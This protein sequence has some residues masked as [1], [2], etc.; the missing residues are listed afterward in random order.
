MCMTESRLQVS[1][2]LLLEE[3]RL[4][5]HNFPGTV[6]GSPTTPQYYHIKHQKMICRGIQRRTRASSVA[7]EARFKTLNQVSPE[8][9]PSTARKPTARTRPIESTSSVSSQERID[10]I[11]SKVT[12]FPFSYDDLMPPQNEELEVRYLMFAVGRIHQATDTDF[13]RVLAHGTSFRELG[14]LHQ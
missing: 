2:A 13:H 10:E 9:T 4:F 5:E 1:L 11:I 8:T 12:L 14:I 7:R 6:C 3:F